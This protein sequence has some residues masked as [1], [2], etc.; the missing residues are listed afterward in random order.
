MPFT[1][2][3]DDDRRRLH[4]NFT[5]F[6]DDDEAERACAAVLQAAHELGSGF[7]IVTDI[8]GFKATTE[9]GA[10]EIA[11]LQRRLG[12]LG[13][14]RVVRV[15]GDSVLANMQLSRTARQAGYGPG[16]RPDAVRSLAEAEELLDGGGGSP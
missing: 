8:S 9:T 2:S 13:V 15:V 1:V 14:R 3:V 6:F 11:R 7:D 12:E 4:V 16:V 5:G 10:E